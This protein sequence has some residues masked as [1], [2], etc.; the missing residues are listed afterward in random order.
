MTHIDRFAVVPFRSGPPPDDALMIGPLD[1]IMQNLPDT[2]ARAD[3][4]ERLEIAR[5]KS[6]QIKVMRDAMPAIK[7]LA[8]CEA[9]AV[10]LP[11]IARWLDSYMQR[12]RAHIK[13]KHEAEQQQIAD[14]LRK[15][16]PLP[17]GNPTRG[18]GAAQAAEPSKIS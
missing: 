7:A 18:E 1:L 15:L 16:P 5:I 12:R 8:F 2:L 4:I 9:A 13:A 17:W 10:A 11:T 14:A 6:D 3:A